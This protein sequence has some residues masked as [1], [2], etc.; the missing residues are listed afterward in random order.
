MRTFGWAQFRA[1]PSIWIKQESDGSYEYTAY[2]VDDFG[3]VSSM[4]ETLI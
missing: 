2:H 4:P 1:D 3:C